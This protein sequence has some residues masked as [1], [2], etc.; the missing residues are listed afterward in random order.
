MHDITLTGK[1]SGYTGRK[2]E[3]IIGDTIISRM[4]S[5]EAMSGMHDEASLPYSK[6]R[7]S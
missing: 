3:S 6:V 4:C 2:S 5:A 7:I 1:E